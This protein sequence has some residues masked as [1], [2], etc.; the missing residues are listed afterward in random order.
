MVFPPRTICVHLCKSVAKSSRAGGIR[1]HD[2]LNPIQ[3]FYQAEL[4]PDS[5]QTIDQLQQNRHIGNGQGA[6]PPDETDDKRN[7]TGNRTTCRRG[8]RFTK[9][10][11]SPKLS[12]NIVYL[13]KIARS[14]CLDSRSDLTGATELPGLPRRIRPV[15]D[16]ATD[17]FAANY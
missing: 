5:V 17:R 10:N 9:L 13:S 3:A 15:S 7:Y 16:C 4:R 2:L 8:D 14:N 11:Y 1:T 12:K 6:R